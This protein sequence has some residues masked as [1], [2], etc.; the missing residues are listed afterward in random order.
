MVLIF[1]NSRLVVEGE[2]N[3]R[4]NKAQPACTSALWDVLASSFV[5]SQCWQTSIELVYS[6]I[7]HKQ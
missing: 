2:Q 1:S 7:A 4:E 5:I 3:Q 6:R